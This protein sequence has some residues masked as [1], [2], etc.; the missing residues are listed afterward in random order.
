MTTPTMRTMMA[1]QIYQATKMFD[2][3]RN[4]NGHQEIDDDA[5]LLL[6]AE[7]RWPDEIDPFAYHGLAGEVVRLISPQTE[8]DPVALLVNFLVAFGNAANRGAYFIADGARHYLNENAALV[9]PTSKGRKG[10]SW[11]Q[12]ATLMR[13]IDPAWAENVASGLVSGE[14]VIY[15]VRDETRAGEEVTDPGVLDKRLMVVESELA[16]ILRVTARDGNT[17]SASLRVAWDT[18]NLRSLSKNSPLKATGAHISVMGH[19]SRDEVLKYLGD[20][21]ISNGLANRFLWVAVRRS[22]ILPEGGEPVDWVGHGII[23]RAHQALQAAY[24]LGEMRRDDDTRYCWAQ[25]YPDLSEGKPGLVGSATAR[26]EA[27]VLRL[28]M[29]YAA[30]DASPVIRWAHLQAA[31]AVWRYCE[32]SAQYIFGANSGNPMAD[33]ILAALKEHEEGMSRTEIRK[34]LGTH[35]KKEEIETALALLSKTGVVRHEEIKRAEGGPVKQVW[36]AVNP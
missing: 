35:A 22:Q 27:H 15:H 29:I 16:S 13:A 34:L 11:N 9:G 8:A 32:Q 7:P 4:G 21:E 30:L 26:A 24:S 23:E 20:V 33:A 3:Q 2:R 6:P 19:V 28:S 10:T 36:F 18:G 25:V 17:L 12:I 5:P 1:S 31:L 14:G